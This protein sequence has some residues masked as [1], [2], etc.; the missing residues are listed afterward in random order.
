M[1]EHYF[2]A[3]DLLGFSNLVSNLDEEKLDQRIQEWVKL[4]ER[5]K[6]GAPAESQ[7]ISD[8]LFYRESGSADGLERM[9]RFCRTLLEASLANALPV[10]GAV[11][12]G[13]VQWGELTYGPAVLEAHRLETAQEWIGIAC[14][15]TMPHIEEMWDW[16][17]VAVYPVPF[18]SG[19][20]RLHPAVAWNVPSVRLLTKQTTSEGLYAEGDLL[21]WDWQRKVIHTFIFGQYLRS[22]KASGQDAKTFIAGSP[23]DLLER[24]ITGEAKADG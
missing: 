9:L 6:P 10:R 2:L 23:A 13:Q 12:F 24:L 1:K 15:A 11:A 20:I 21:S 16:E 8:T 5:I 14:A 17:R 4:I 7:L 18:K 3:A 22:A 19:P